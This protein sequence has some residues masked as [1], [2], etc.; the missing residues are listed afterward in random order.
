MTKK[1]KEL[2]VAAELRKLKYTVPFMP[3]RITTITGVTFTIGSADFA[4]SPKGDE[5]IMY[6][7]GEDTLRVLDLRHVLSVKPVRNGTKKRRKR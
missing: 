5:A 4:I 6:P 1:L 3:F 2:P 7:V